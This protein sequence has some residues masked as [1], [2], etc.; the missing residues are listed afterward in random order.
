MITLGRGRP[1]TSTHFQS[2]FP[3]RDSQGMTSKVSFQNE[4]E[5]A[6]GNV[7]NRPVRDVYVCSILIL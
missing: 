7:F 4:R 6:A 5:E 1:S 2:T 3:S